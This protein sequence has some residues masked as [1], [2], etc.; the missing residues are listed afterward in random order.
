MTPQETDIKNKPNLFILGAPK[1]GTTSLIYWLSQ[2]PGVF[3]CPEKEPCVFYHPNRKPMSW[4]S[5][6]RLYK[7]VAEH[8]QTIVEASI[9]YLFSKNA[10]ND[11]LNFNPNAK[12]VVCLRNPTDMFFSL[13]NQKIVSGQERFLDPE[14]A[15]NASDARDSG[16]KM[17]ISG[18]PYGDPRH[19]AYKKSCALGSQ[20]ARLLEV[21]PRDSV[22]FTVLDRLQLNPEYEFSR[23]CRWIGADPSAQMDFSAKNSAR[24]PKSMMVTRIL[25]LVSNMKRISGWRGN[26]GFLAPISKLNSR[27][28]V[29]SAPA[30]EL[31]RELSIFFAPEVEKLEA[32]TGEDFSSWK[33]SL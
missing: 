25:L 6:L 14:K 8:H 2:L 22:Y 20:V 15:W 21:V 12:F 13:H 24:N 29:T 10:V 27:Q 23:F 5:Y 26:T 31:Y 16:R 28:K 4:Q 32:L 1:C 9:W 3:V 33:P 11:V 30:E 17:G 18:M 7:G 19:M